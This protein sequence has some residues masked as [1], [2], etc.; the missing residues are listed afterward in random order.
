MNED[1]GVV[2]LCEVLF[3]GVPGTGWYFHTQMVQHGK[4]DFRLLESREFYS[5]RSFRLDAG[6]NSLS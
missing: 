4:K 6:T 1:Y 2:E 5:Y 3:Y